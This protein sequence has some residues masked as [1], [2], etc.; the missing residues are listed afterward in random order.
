MIPALAL[1]Q[2]APDLSGLAGS[3][4][5]DLSRYLAV[6]ALLILL[7]AGLGVGYR[8]LAASGWR[9]RARGRALTAVDVLPLGGRQKLAVVRC[10]DKSFLIGLGEKELCL[11]AALDEEAQKSDQAPELT[12][13]DAAAPPQKGRF[14]ATLRAKAG[15]AAL[16]PRSQARSPAAPRLPGGGLLG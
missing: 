8:T 3:E 16:L 13:L 12:A 15:D 9:G 7:V 5:P 1:V 11:I 10:Y 6:C 4:G 14:L 2:G